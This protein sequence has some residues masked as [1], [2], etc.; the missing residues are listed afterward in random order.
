MTA[1]KMGH[2]V[3]AKQQQ[4]EEEEVEFD[5]ETDYDGEPQTA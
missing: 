2:L 3:L 5:G 4:Q 1:Y